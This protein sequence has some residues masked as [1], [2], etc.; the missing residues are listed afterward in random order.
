MSKIEIH[1][2]EE[3]LQQNY[4]MEVIKTLLNFPQKLWK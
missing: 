2:L 1:N 3:L 4:P